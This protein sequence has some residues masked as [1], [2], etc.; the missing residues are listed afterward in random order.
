MIQEIHNLKSE[1]NDLTLKE[2]QAEE[3]MNAL[4]QSKN[5]KK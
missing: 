1:V 4:R 5:R 3:E 2:K